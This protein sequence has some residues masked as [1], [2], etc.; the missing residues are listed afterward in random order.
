[1]TTAFPRRGWRAAA[2]LGAAL[3]LAGCAG[4]QDPGRA[5]VEYRGTD[6]SGA[7]QTESGPG[8][9]VARDGYY[10]A[11]AREGDTVETLAARAGVPA[12]DLGAY[13][14][15]SAKA[16]LRAGEE[17][18]LPPRPEG[19]EV[20]RAAPGDPAA[21]APRR[22]EPAPDAAIEDAPL[23]ER[24]SDASATPGP[25]EE[26][27]G[28]MVEPGGEDGGWSPD[29]AAAAIDRASGAET[30]DGAAGPGAPPS[31]GDPLPPDPDPAPDLASPEL[32]RYQSGAP[33]P[34]E[35]A[36]TY[37][38]EET[39]Q[40]AP[41]P[42]ARDAEARGT[43]TPQ[44]RPARSAPGEERSADTLRPDLDPGS[45]PEEP[46]EDLAAREV[47]AAVP[48]PGPETEPEPE[49][50]PAGEGRFLRPVSGP[51]AIGFGPRPEGGRNEGVDFAAPAGSPVRAAADGEVALVSE[52]LGGLGTIVLLR[53][54]DDLLT[55]YGRLSDVGVAK[56][57]IV[58]RGQRIGA[59][60]A[61]EPPAEA[62]M[63]FEIRE[64]ADAVDPMA[65]LGG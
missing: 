37:A 26:A 60:A 34:R 55:V 30:E 49:P 4:T 19:Y 48:D 23:E 7:P 24:A 35:T 27:P 22:P 53:H 6:P 18:V 29:L 52:A 40:I 3:G 62:R 65:Y 31:V 39:G 50:E 36:D 41:T 28:A 45:L 64:G 12:A 21:A 61:P 2:L 59:V 33:A 14:G 15:R 38:A 46:S 54:P 32:G 1:M 47:D 8:A 58:S 16:P 5:R 56:G 11:V 9:I 25:A 44:S 10:T 51:V 20:A 13:N 57:D 17:L 42:E 43:P 63:H